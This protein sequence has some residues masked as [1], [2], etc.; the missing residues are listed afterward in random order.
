MYGPYISPTVDGFR[1]P[2][3]TTWDV[4]KGDKLWFAPSTV[5]A[6]WKLDTPP[7][8]WTCPLKN[9]GWKMIHFLLKCSLFGVSIRPIVRGTSCL[10]RSLVST[11]WRYGA[12]PRPGG[13]FGRFTMCELMDVWCIPCI[14]WSDFSQ[15]QLASLV[16]KSPYLL[17]KIHLQMVDLPLYHSSFSGEEIYLHLGNSECPLFRCWKNPPKEGPIKTKGHLFSRYIY[18]V[19]FCIYYI[20][21][22]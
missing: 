14:Y 2:T 12:C 8:K 5:W 21:I 17:G 10:A 1:N 6:N 3:I 11:Q 18:F 9:S 4:K 7:E 20:I 16:G 15:P 19:L 13:G 22:F